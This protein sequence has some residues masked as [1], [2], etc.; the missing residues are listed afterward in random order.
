MV[1]KCNG[2]DC[3][4]NVGNDEYMYGSGI[5]F[6]KEMFMYKKKV[7]WCMVMYWLWNDYW[8]WFRNCKVELNVWFWNWIGM[9]YGLEIESE[10]CMVF[11]MR[12]ACKFFKDLNEW[13]W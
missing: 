6:M 11:G 5:W 9:M 2:N 8:N 7:E 4:L 13:I 10:W 3:N 12:M 1:W